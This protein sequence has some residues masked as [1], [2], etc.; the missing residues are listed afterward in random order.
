MKEMIHNA[1]K[2][3][4]EDETQKQTQDAR[5]EYENYLHHTKLT[6]QD[7]K[8]KEKIGDKYAELQERI[9]KAEEILQVRH[10]AKEEYEQVQKQLESYVNSIMYSMADID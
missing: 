10:V 8:V 2:Y 3:K 7:D 9:Q 4:E 6:I 1:E 5:N